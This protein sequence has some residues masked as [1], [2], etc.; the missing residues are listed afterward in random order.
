MEEKETRDELVDIF[1]GNIGE[2]STRQNLRN[3]IYRLKKL[4]GQELLTADHRKVSLGKEVSVIR[5]TD[6]LVADDGNLPIL[7]LEDTVF[8]NG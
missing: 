7:E 1:G 5:D 8:L 6:G 2:E 3:A 4:L